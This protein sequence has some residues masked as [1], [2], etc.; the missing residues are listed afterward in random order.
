LSGG[1]EEKLFK[2]H[3]SSDPK[4]RKRAACFERKVRGANVDNGGN[5][6]LK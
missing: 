1:R 4:Q 2:I 5:L 6:I 3:I